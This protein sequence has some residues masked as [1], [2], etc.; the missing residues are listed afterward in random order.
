MVARLDGYAEQASRN[1][2]LQAEL[3]TKRSRRPTR[4]FDLFA[5]A[6]PYFETVAKPRRHRGDESKTQDLSSICTKEKIRW[7]S[8]LKR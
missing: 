1:I 2:Y 5:A 3:L 8:L 7:Q 6:E 4:D